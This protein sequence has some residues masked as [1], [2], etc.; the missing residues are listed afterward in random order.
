VRGPEAGIAVVTEAVAVEARVVGDVPRGLLEIGGESRPLENLRQEVR[1]PLARNVRA[2]EL[3]HRVVA[4]AEEDAVVQLGR[5]R[6][7]CALDRR[8][9]RDRVGELVQEEAAQRAWVAR[10]AR[11]ERALDRLRQVDEPEDR[12]IEVGEMRSEALALLVR[13]GF[14]R[15]WQ[16]FHGGHGI[17]NASAGLGR[18][19]RVVVSHLAARLLSGRA[20]PEG[21]PR[22][23]RRAL[24]DGRA[25]HDRIP[26]AGRGA[27]PPLGGAGAGGIRVRA[28]AA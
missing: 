20:R 13:E 21:V 16:A 8:Y 4:V 1:R 19:V 23:L 22:L 24:P 3:R 9:F 15:E 11:E 12:A 10:V 18:N 2:A 28:E 5:A 6:A 26:R 17:A 27:V 25:E 7:L 14:D